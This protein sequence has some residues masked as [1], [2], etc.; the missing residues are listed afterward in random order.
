MQTG[1]GK[2]LQTAHGSRYCTSEMLLYKHAS[3]YLVPYFACSRSLRAWL[4]I[5]KMTDA[6]TLR[7]MHTDA[8]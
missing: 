4:A 5:H 2:T 8:A 6:V 1:S 7:K 3:K